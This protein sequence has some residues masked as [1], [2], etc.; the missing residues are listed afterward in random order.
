MRQRIIA[1]LDIGTHAL[2]MGLAKINEESGDLE[3]MDVMSEES[4]GV[5]KGTVVNV[6]ELARRVFSLK[7]RMESTHDH[8]IEGVYVNVGGSHL[9]T[10]SSHGIVVV[11][12]ADGQISQED[13]DR[14]LQAAQ[15]FSLPRN[16]EILDVF[17]QQYI[18]DGERGVK[19][20]VNMK[21]VRLEVDVLAVCGFS[22][23]IKN[24]TEAVLAGGLEVLDVISSPLAASPAVLTPQQ[25]EIG[26]ALLDIGGG[27]T[28]LAVFEEGNVIHAAVFPVGSD[29]MTNDIAI[30]LRTEYDAAERV[31]I[32]YGSCNEK[33]GKRTGKIALPSGEELV[34]QQSLVTSILD[35][36]V[37][38]IFQLIF[39]E[40]KKISKDGM[41]PAGV[42]LTGGGA[43]LPGLVEFAKKEFK[44]PVRIGTP[45]GLLTGQTAPEYLGVLGLIAA[46]AEAEE[47][48]MASQKPSEM[49]KKIKK[50]FK[51]FIP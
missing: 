24:L 21:G 11:S 49:A 48:A 31:K 4:F 32:E 2:K 1:G 33:P 13:V 28:S 30:G 6:E 46:G 19:E 41:L 39:K 26:A 3:V 47:S 34:F 16:K 40:L 43:K 25:K 14:V 17:P 27:C 20:V 10:V 42:V 38:E 8:H 36:R 50:F 9:Y 5:R 29:N 37:K 35:A 45:Q 7:T 12:R 44:L 18:V 15:T 22:P 23:Y 51:S